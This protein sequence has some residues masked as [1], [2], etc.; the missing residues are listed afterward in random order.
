[1]MGMIGGI[2]LVMIGCAKRISVNYEEV[3]KTNSVNVRMVSG[4]KA[5]G[6][7]EKVE[8]HQLTLMEKNRALR[9]ISKP[10]IVEIRRKP[11]IYDDFG[12]GI[13]ESEINNRKS[14]GNTLVYGLGG[15]LLSFG[16]SFFI[17]S[18]ISQQTEHGSTALLLTTGVGGTLGT[19]LFTR[20]G[21]MRDRKIAIDKIKD[22]RRA[23]Q[24]TIKKEK[25]EKSSEE[26][27]KMLLEEKAKQDTLRKERERLLKELEK[28]RK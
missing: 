28:E 16:T 2:F 22:E 9:V 21:S 12:N 18:L 15:G 6:I 3:E 7:V 19:V 20:A 24:I 25:Q 4:K 11:P 1:M 10:S 8:P 13:S 14:I 27:E 5:S 17:G 23:V 26:I